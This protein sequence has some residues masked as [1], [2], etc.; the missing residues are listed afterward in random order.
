MRLNKRIAALCAVACLAAGAVVPTAAF[1]WGN[2]QQSKCN[3]GNGNGSESLV[4]TA[5]CTSGD[6]GNSFAAG[7]KGGD[8]VPPGVPNPGGNNVGPI[9]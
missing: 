8:E 2:Q 7:N 4:D 6:P 5:H 1:A 3:S 9:D